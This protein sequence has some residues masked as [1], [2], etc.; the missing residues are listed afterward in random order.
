MPQQPFIREHD[1]GEIPLSS[2][3][4]LIL[5]PFRNEEHSIPLYLK[6]LE[7]V[8]YPRDLIDVY[9]LENDSSD[10]TLEMLKEAEPTMPFKT[11]LESINIF[12]PIEKATPGGYWKDLPYGGKRIIT[13]LAIWN[14]YF[15][16]IIRK[17]NSEYALFWFADIVVPK[18]VITEFLTVFEV[19][20]DAGWVGGA[21]HRRYPRQDELSSPWFIG[22]YAPVREHAHVKPP[23][24]ITEVETTAHCWMMPKEAFEDGL[25]A[26]SKFRWD[27]STAITDQL[28]ENGYKAYYQPS[29]Y[30]KH[31]STDGKIYVHGLE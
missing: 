20:P 30:I 6:S 5:T 23:S 31:I 18:N 13:W 22:R 14:E 19:K 15:S 17:S 24:S 25:E 8:E 12:G 29:V 9:W 1:G 21:M 4:I 2:P 7:S 10:R 28:R 16:P 3:K 11:T 26:R 27:W